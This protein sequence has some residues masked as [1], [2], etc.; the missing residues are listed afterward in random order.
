YLPNPIVPVW[1]TVRVA[2]RPLWS[3]P[4][5]LVVITAGTTL[6]PSHAAASA[7]PPLLVLVVGETA[8]SDHFALNGYPR[9]TTPELA[10]RGVLSF[11][12]VWSCGTNTL[13][14]VPCMFSSLG[15]AAYEAREAN[16]E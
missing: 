6:G 13:A 16:Y 1:S 7:K 4:K 11:R 9:D 2:S 8:R 12:N 10:A 15:K 3:R 5:P 14:S